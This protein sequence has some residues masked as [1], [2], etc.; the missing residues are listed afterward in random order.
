MAELVEDEGFQPLRIQAKTLIAKDTWCF[1]LVHPEAGALPAFTA[2]A[3]VVLQTPCGIRRSYSLCN[4]PAETER[5]VLAVKAEQ[6]GRGG[7]RSLVNDTREGDLLMVS[8]PQNN[9]PLLPAQEYVFIAGGIGITP[10]MSMLRQLKHAQAKNFR[11][12]YC[13]RNPESTA[14]ID[15]LTGAEFSGRVSLHHDD[16]DPA[17]V[18][19]LWP[20]FESPRKVH[21]YCCGPA[22]MLTEIRDM[23]GHWPA[24]AI[25]ME[26]FGSDIELVKADDRAFTVRHADTGERVEI[27]AQATILETL[28]QQ[29]H[30]LPSSCESGTCGTCK[31]ELV[32]GEADHRDLVLTDDER[33][34]YIMIC[35]SRALSDELELRW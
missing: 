10:I 12:I 19:D 24:S 29:G 28:R 18:F 7:S 23:S 13:T 16:G 34:R 31:T 20:V 27:P 8:T 9:F 3:N 30:H 35:V 17:R 6:E 25:H 33:S 2:G 15:E 22:A 14:F 1:E 11:L 26:D 32:A 4:D 21:V 5:Y